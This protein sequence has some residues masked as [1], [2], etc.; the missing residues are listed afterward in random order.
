MGGNKKTRKASTEPGR[1][2]RPTGARDKS[3]RKASP[4]KG[5]ASNAKK[6]DKNPPKIRQAQLIELVVEGK[7]VA[8]IAVKL[9]VNTSTIYRWLDLPVVAAE[10]DARLQLRIVT[11]RRVIQAGAAE[12]AA[13]MVEVAIKGGA[14]NAQVR[15]IEAVLD[16]A[17]LTAPKE[18]KVS[19]SLDTRPPSTEE[20]QLRKARAKERLAALEERRGNAKG[21]ED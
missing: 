6:C 14:D 2:G 19:G 21:K 16:R 11:A 13:K 3:P 7:P 15:A 10:I 17:G 1:V 4:R 18:L 5:R 8:D 12:V 20:L 9:D